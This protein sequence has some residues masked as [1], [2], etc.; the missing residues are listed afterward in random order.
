MLAEVTG[1][2]PE[3]AQIAAAVVGAVGVRPTQVRLLGPGELPKTSSGKIQRS[4]CRALIAN[5]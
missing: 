2:A 3:P 1:G 5:A 4:V